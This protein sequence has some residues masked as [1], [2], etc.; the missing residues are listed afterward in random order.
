MLSS[1]LSLSLSFRPMGSSRSS[2]TEMERSLKERSLKKETKAFICWQT[3]VNETQRGFIVPPG[4]VDISRWKRWHKDGGGGEG[5]A[6]DGGLSGGVT[7][8]RFNWSWGFHWHQMLNSLVLVS[9]SCQHV[10]HL[11]LTIH[12]LEPIRGLVLPPAHWAGSEGNIALKRDQQKIRPI[13]SVV[14][15]KGPLLTFFIGFY[16]D[17]F[18]FFFFVSND[19]TNL[20][21]I[22]PARQVSWF[23]RCDLQNVVQTLNTN[24]LISSSLTLWECLCQKVKEPA[25]RLSCHS[26]RWISIFND[27]TARAL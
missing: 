15:W 13:T 20:E 19:P 14:V 25:C 3:L 9:E 24:N 23:H 26:R 12:Q 6:R 11:Q 21:N 22:H 18:F 8:F 16:S 17:G 10:T 1:I 5:G 2:W 7:H 27:R 4:S